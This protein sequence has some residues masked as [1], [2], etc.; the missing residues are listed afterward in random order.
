MAM[1]RTMD[2]RGRGG[3]RGDAAESREGIEQAV[4]LLGR[5]TA[6]VFA[7]E[8]RGSRSRS[9]FAHAG[10]CVRRADT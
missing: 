4:D 2:V 5:I 6:P 3:R 10:L 9:P 1:A 7:M 8:S